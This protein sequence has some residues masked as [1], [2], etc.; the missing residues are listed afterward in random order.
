MAVSL[1]GVIVRV[2]AYLC[3]LEGFCRF[4]IVSSKGVIVRIIAYSWILEG[5]CRFVGC[6]CEGGDCQNYCIC[7]DT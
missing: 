2:T 1:K 7:V 3:M 5:F 6:E 4:L